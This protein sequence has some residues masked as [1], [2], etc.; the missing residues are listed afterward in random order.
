MLSNDHVLA[1]IPT[2]EDVHHPSYSKCKSQKVGERLT[3]RIVD[4]GTDR[5]HRGIADAAIAKLKSKRGRDAPKG[6]PVIVD[7]GPVK[8][9][10]AIALS[11]IQVNEDKKRGY[12]VRKRGVTT[13]LTEGIVTSING[14]FDVDETKIYLKDQIL[15]TPMA[16]SGRGVFA[17]KGDSGAAVVNDKNEVVGLVV[18]VDPIGVGFASPIKVIESNLKVTVWKDESSPTTTP[19][20]PQQPVTVTAAFPEVLADVTSEVLST[21]TGA[22]YVAL[23]Q[24]HFNEIDTLIHQNKRVAAT[25]RRNEGPAFLLELQRFIEVRT[26]PLP[27]IIN[28]KPLVECL[29]KIVAAFRQFGSP[30]LVADI[31]TFTPEAYRRIN[32]SYLEVLR[33]LNATGMA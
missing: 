27:A 18:G 21:G 12:R 7:I 5:T 16:G 8:G 9:S 14:T 4:H 17:A 6:D 30:R 29:E 3:N 11:D 10:V 23:A 33:S 19:T 28:G 13:L 1:A 2:N 26:S 24:Q 25:W 22:R 20:Q 31:A 15:I 32:M